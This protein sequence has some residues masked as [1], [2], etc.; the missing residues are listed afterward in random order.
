MKSTDPAAK[1][2]EHQIHQAVGVFRALEQHHEHQAHGQ[3][4]GHIGQKVDG[5]EQLLAGA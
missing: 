5:L 2:V 4:V 1:P 3:G